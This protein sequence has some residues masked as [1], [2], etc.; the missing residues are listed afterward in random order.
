M[1]MIIMIIVSLVSVIPLSMG[2]YAYNCD[3]LSNAINTDIIVDG[4][5]GDSDEDDDEEGLVWSHYN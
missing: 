5:D 4:E 1:M 2:E 3:S